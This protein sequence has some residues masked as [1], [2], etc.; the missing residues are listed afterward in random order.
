MLESTGHDDRVQEDESEV[1]ESEMKDWEDDELLKALE[2]WGLVEEYRIDAQLGYL[3]SG[4]GEED[5]YYGEGDLDI[6]PSSPL[7]Q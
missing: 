5:I 4:M 1:W 7:G 2:D 6:C 3:E